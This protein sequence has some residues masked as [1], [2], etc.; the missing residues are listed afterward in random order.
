MIA[1][2]EF[3][4]MV[5]DG[6]HTAHNFMARHHGVLG[7]A[8]VIANIVKVRVAYATVKDVD[9]NIIRARVSPDKVEKS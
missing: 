2:F 8:P 5:A 3:G 9:D 6:G 7:V 1:H 4:H